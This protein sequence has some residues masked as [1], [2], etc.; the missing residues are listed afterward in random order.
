MNRFK[1]LIPYFATFLAVFYLLPL[2]YWLHLPKG[3]AIAV[4]LL[5]NPAF[6]LG[7]GMVYTAKHGFCWYFLFLPILFL[8]SAFLYYNESAVFYTW[9]YLA[10]TLGGI[11]LGLLLRK[12]AE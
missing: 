5:V 6:C 3:W 4:L 8:P 10:L 7:S 1:R 9:V 11:G 12:K 2:T